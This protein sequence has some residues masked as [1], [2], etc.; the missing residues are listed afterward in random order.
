MLTDVEKQ[1]SKS[2]NPSVFVD[3]KA[4]FD[5]ANQFTVTDTL[6]LT[7]VFYFVTGQVLADRL[8]ISLN[9]FTVL[10]LELLR[11]DAGPVS[12]VALLFIQRVSIKSWSGVHWFTST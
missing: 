9:P 11:I 1:R 5:N 6:D 2:P 12:D 8:L 10:S 7:N 3:F 4:P